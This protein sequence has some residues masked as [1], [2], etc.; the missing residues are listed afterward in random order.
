MRCWD[1]WE[2]KQ[3][4]SYLSS[5]YLSIICLYLPIIYLLFYYERQN[6]KVIK[7]PRLGASLPSFESCFL[8]CG[9]CSTWPSLSMPVSASLNGFINS[10]VMSTKWIIVRKTLSQ[11]HSESYVSVC[12]YH[13]PSLQRCKF[14][15]RML[16]FTLGI[17]QNLNIE[18]NLCLKYVKSMDT[19][20]SK[21]CS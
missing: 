8:S 13:C 17:L 6:N 3:S 10:I 21:S 16:Y 9:N 15:N 11:A 18:I 12:F 20:L 4:S 2:K 5:I 19:E 1:D 7:K 14:S